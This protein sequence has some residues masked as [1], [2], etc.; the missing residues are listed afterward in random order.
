MKGESSL[1]E[2][3]LWIYLD[4]F[5]QKDRWVSVSIDKSSAAIEFCY[6]QC[7]AGKGGTCSHAY[8][9]LHL[10]ANWSLEQLKEI[11]DPVPCTSTLCAWNVPQAR[12][13]TDTPKFSSLTFPKRRSSQSAK[14]NRGGKKQC[15]EQ[16]L[17][18]SDAGDVSTL[19]GSDDKDD[20]DFEAQK[21]SRGIS[22]NL[23]EARAA[24]KQVFNE[25]EVETL[26]S[27]ISMGE[28]SNVPALSLFQKGTP[29]GS[30]LTPFGKVPVGSPLSNQCPFID[31]G[32]HIY[33]SFTKSY[34]DYNVQIPDADYPHFPVNIV[35]DF[36]DKQLLNSV[37][38]P[39][40]LQILKNLMID[41]NITNRVELETQD[42]YLSKNWGKERFSRFT[43]SFHK[44]LKEKKTERGFTN[45]AKTC[46]EK[47][48]ET[49]TQNSFLKKKL[50]QGR[51][52]EPEAIKAYKTYAMLNGFPLKYGKCGLVLN[53]AYY[54]MGASPDG[55]IID[56]SLEGR[57]KF[58]IIEVKCPE[59]FKEV[60]PK[61]V[62][63]VSESFCLQVSEDGEL[64][65]NKDHPYY[66]Q[67]QHQQ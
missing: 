3:I 6:C 42:Q 57:K 38:D 8:A 59:Q 24:C 32:Y 35:P 30:I 1:S 11:P 48:Q 12:G 15:R 49:A 22:S 17:Q 56:A 67:I 18:T 62:A 50:D 45:L 47:R 65:I 7:E 4:L 41:D 10:L 36:T 52:F 14:G 13:R 46:L 37:T 27:K 39:K 29:F 26:L 28:N 9:V 34:K 60:D 63:L 44:D 31:F 53:T 51:F 33:C 2:R 40:Q 25:N 66:D 23:Y 54:F 64:K 55:K 43:A 19:F 61:H 5:R 21:E 20:I 58:G 16:E